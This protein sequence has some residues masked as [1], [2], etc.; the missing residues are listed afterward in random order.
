MFQEIPGR[1]AGGG[2]GGRVWP[3]QQGGVLG[4][5]EAAQ[6]MLEGLAPGNSNDNDL[7]VFLTPVI[8]FFIIKMTLA[9]L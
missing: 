8:F 5:T 4:Q 3:G 9:E 6:E 1:L 7:N 2:E